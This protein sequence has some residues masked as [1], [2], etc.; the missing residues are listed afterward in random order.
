[1]WG[2]QEKHGKDPRKLRINPGEEWNSVLG[3][4]QEDLLEA[5]WAKYL[6][7]R[8]YK[9]AEWRS[10]HHQ[11][12]ELNPEK[13]NNRA[14][15]KKPKLSGFTFRKLGRRAEKNTG[16]GIHELQTKTN[17]RNEWTPRL[18]FIG[19]SLHIGQRHL[20]R[21]RYDFFELRAELGW[22]RRDH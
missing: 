11:I 16:W 18:S 4:N 19:H 8:V 9:Q 2:L 21:R 17:R 6:H 5:W 22:A 13:K 12:G 10:G 3:R 7:R 15:G 20:E 14:T 1:M